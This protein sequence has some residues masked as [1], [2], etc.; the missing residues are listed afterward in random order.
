MVS[1]NFIY[2][3]AV[4]LVLG[5]KIANELQ[6]VSWK[7]WLKAVRDFFFGTNESGYTSVTFIAV[8]WV[9]CAWYTGAVWG[10]Q[11][12]LPLHP[13]IALLLGSLVELLVPPVAKR[14]ITMI[15][16]AIGGKDA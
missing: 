14:I 13:A 16:N 7:L 3:F 5:I 9:I 1:L 10:G 11:D 8:A 2:W 15:T 4:A 6:D 12:T